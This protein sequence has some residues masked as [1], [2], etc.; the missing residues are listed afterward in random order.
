MLA[1]HHDKAVIHEGVLVYR[2]V[3]FIIVN[4]CFFLFCFS[5]RQCGQGLEHRLRQPDWEP[6]LSGLR[7]NF[8]SIYALLPGQVSRLC[9]FV[10]G[11]VAHRWDRDPSYDG[12]SGMWGGR[13]TRVG[14]AW[15]GRTVG[16]KKLGSV[17]QKTGSRDIDRCFPLLALLT[18]LKQPLVL[19]T[20]LCTAGFS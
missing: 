8:L 18:W 12:K 15:G 11:A 9:C 5:H 2:G 1:R 16:N 3:H 6:H 17:I 7:G 19:G 14:K 13:G 10:P 4:K 20:N